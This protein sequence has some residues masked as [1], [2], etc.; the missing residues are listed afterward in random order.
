MAISI[1]TFFTVKCNL[2]SSLPAQV[3][4]SVECPLRGTGVH[5]FNPR[6][7]HTKVIKNDTSCS[8]CGTRWGS[9]SEDWAPSRNQT[10]SWY[11][12][13]IVEMLN[14]NKQQQKEL[15]DFWRGIFIWITDVI[16]AFFKKYKWA[17]S[18]QNQQND[19]VPS[20]DSDQPGHPPS[21]VSLRCML[22]G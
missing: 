1:S 17:I 21:L 6:P 15:S 18:W 13:K 14:P 4:Q 19:C 10:Q 2:M 5:G 20:K 3:G 9:T 7:R 11:D 8:S 16:M 12:W 22:N